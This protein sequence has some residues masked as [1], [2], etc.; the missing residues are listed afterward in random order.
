VTLD[1]S[2][3]MPARVLER[4]VAAERT[5]FLPLAAGNLR[6]PPT[7]VGWPP[8]TAGPAG[9]A[10]GAGVLTV[11]SFTIDRAGY[12]ARRDPH[13]DKLAASESRAD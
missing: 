6:H 10:G 9:R 7:L 4:L 13:P 11:V 5:S 12:R 8:S 1:E 3:S 2:V